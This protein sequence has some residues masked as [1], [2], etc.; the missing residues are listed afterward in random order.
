M[1]E[2]ELKEG[3][4]KIQTSSCKIIKDVLYNTMIIANYASGYI[5]KRINPK[6]SHHKNSPPP[7]L[8]LSFFSFYCICMRRWMFAETYSG[9]HFTIYVNQTIMV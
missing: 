4:Q 8:F 5:E 9:N 2:G 1:T 6:T 7:L 3:G